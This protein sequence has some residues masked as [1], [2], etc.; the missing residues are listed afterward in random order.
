MR[1]LF[2]LS[3]VTREPHPGATAEDG[4]VL[5]AASRRK[6]ATYLGLAAGG[7]RTLCVLGCEVDGGTL[8]HCI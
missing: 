2:R 6:R 4:T 5:R 7:T 8:T 3:R 1:P